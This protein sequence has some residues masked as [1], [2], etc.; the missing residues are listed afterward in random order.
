VLVG[1][2]FAGL[3]FLYRYVRR[4]GRL[5]AGE[6]TVVDRRASHPYIPLAHEALSGAT[7]PDALRFD[8]RA[9][10]HAIGAAF[11]EAEAIALAAERSAVVL[12]GG[13]ELPYDRV[14]LAVGSVPAVPAGFASDERVVPAKFVADALRLRDCLRVLHESGVASPHVVVAGGGITGVEWA[15]E[16]AG[17]GVDGRRAR[18]SIVER[19]DRLLSTFA[20]GVARRATRV[21]GELGVR[22]HLRRSIASV[23]GDGVVLDDGARVPADVVLWAGGVRPAPVVA[24]LAR[25]GL[26]LTESGHL[27]VTPRLLVRGVGARASVGAA[28]AIG[29]AVRVVA[30]GDPWPTMERAIEAIW[31]GALLG[32]RLAAGHAPDAGPSHRLRRTFFYGL[33]L[34]P[35]H[36]LVVYERFAF[37]SRLNVW[38]RRWLKWAYYARFRLLARALGARERAAEKPTATVA[39]DERGQRRG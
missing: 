17:T 10:C 26:E 14:I 15:A 9:F 11:V 12:A 19:G 37:D 1:C 25:T 7:S 16:L 29:D 8:T 31:Q 35:R 39:A 4:R 38:F 20:P 36:S 13:A 3:E 6:L 34:G 5:R 32:R 28:Y 30:G 2:S 33:S 27:A 23:A 18:V 22:L 21:L 24:T